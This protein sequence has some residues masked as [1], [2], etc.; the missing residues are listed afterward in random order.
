MSFSTPVLATRKIVFARKPLISASCLRDRVTD[1]FDITQLDERLQSY[2]SNTAAT[3]D[4][5]QPDTKPI[6]QSD[7]NASPYKYYLPK[8]FLELLTL[9]RHFVHRRFQSVI[10]SSRILNKGGP[11]RNW[12]NSY[13]PISIRWNNL[14]L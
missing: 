5:E 11:H 9:L 6:G 7:N 10:V 1:R 13:G 8:R 3:S 12:L 2:W 4:D 14:K